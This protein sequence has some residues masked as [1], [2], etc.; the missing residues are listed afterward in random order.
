MRSKFQLFS[1]M[2]ATFQGLLHQ[3]GTCTSLR[4]RCGKVVLRHSQPTGLMIPSVVLSMLDSAASLV[5]DFRTLQG[6]R[7]VEKKA[8]LVEAFTLRSRSGVEPNR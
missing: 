8:R 6:W 7:G 4:P 5:E 2:I 3:G 1:G